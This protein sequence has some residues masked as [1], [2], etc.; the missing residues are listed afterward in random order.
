[1]A[2]KTFEEI[3][4][5][6]FQTPRILARQVCELLKDLEVAPTSI[7]EPNCGQ[8]NL[9]FEALDIFPNVKQAIG[10]DVSSLYIT[11]VK[12]QL[13]SHPD[14]G[15]VTLIE[16]DFFKTNWPEIIR[17]LCEPILIIGNPPWVTNAQVTVLNG[18]NVPVKSNF[19]SHS[20]LDAKMGKS[21][22]DISEWMLIQFLGLLNNRT[23]KMAML[24]KT[25]VAR[26]LLRHAY[27]NNISL[28]HS[29]IY[30]IDAAKHFGAMVDACLF[31]CHF[32][33]GICQYD[34]S[35]YETIH[36]SAPERVIGYRDEVLVS[37]VSL[38]EKWKHLKGNEIYKWRSGIKHD[39]SKIMELTK[40]GERYR[41]GLG[42]LADIEDT[43]LYPMLKTSEVAKPVANPT[44]YMIVTQQTVGGDTSTIKEVAPMTW[45]YLE[46]HSDLFDKRGS[47]IYKN[48][49]RFSVFGIGDYSFS[50]WKVAISGFY[51]RFQF[52]VIGPVEGK[53]V[54][55]DD[56]SYFVPCYSEEEAVLV[57]ILLNSVPAKEFFDSLTFWDSKRP[58]TIDLLRKIDLLKVARELNLDMELQKVLDAKLKEPKRTRTRKA[59]PQSENL[60]L[61]LI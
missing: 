3:E 2:H 58:I 13:R 24:C 37:K 50:P 6:D 48:R 29:S 20:G 1:M 43:F 40:E 36:A 61:L 52:K 45:A 25:A 11:A 51:K 53:S 28:S 55:L 30:R 10:L 42:H 39:C 35:V 47:V 19:Q 4:F 27:K 34:C 32:E 44:R 26:K 22:F 12:S 41:N 49:P 7:I 56:S 21:N 57:G 17:D 9:L 8:G 5:G 15:K 31:I 18:L 23:A 54:V 59:L 60:E 38:Y 33:R 14:E 46:T 16:E